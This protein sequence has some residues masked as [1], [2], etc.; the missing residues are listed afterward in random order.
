MIRDKT[1]LLGEKIWR[2]LMEEHMSKWKQECNSN[3]SKLKTIVHHQMTKHK[4]TRNTE[5][6]PSD[7]EVNAK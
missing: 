1:H 2:S 3:T 6:G 7:K 4:Q 5:E